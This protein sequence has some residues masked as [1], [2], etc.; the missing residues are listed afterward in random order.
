MRQLQGLC[1]CKKDKKV[2]IVME[3]Q[4]LPTWVL[5]LAVL[6]RDFF[7]VSVVA[8]YSFSAFAIFSCNQ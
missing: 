3:G 2:M 1:K 8:S 7:V 5:R 4:S 6:N